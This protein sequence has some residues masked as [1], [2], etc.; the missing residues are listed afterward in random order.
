MYFLKLIQ[1]SYFKRNANFQYFIF[2]GMSSV[3]VMKNISDI[4][5]CSFKCI[6][7][8]MDILI[9]SFIMTHYVIMARWS[10]ATFLCQFYHKIV[11]VV[12]IFEYYTMIYTYDYLE[13]CISIFGYIL[14]IVL[15]LVRLELYHNVRYYPFILKTD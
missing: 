13:L 6:W 14:L 2:S 7:M 15:F 1:I 5:K 10:P 4:S 11:I 12:Y 9:F 8:T 3:T